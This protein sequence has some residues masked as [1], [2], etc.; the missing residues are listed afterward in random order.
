MSA[1]ELLELTPYTYETMR[2]GAIE[3]GIEGKQIEM[4]DK[5]TGHKPN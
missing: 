2:E 4:F 1:N 5:L 3:A